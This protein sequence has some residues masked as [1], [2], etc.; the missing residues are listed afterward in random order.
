MAIKIQH[1]FF[2]KKKHVDVKPTEKSDLS[3]SSLS[4]NNKSTISKSDKENSQISAQKS[5]QEILDS[6]WSQNSAGD[7]IRLKILQKMNHAKQIKEQQKKQGPFVNRTRTPSRTADVALKARQKNLSKLI[8]IVQEAEKQK[9][10]IT[11]KNSENI[12]EKLNK[13]LTRKINKIRGNMKSVSPR[14]KLFLN[15]SNLIDFKDIDKSP[16]NE[17]KVNTTYISNRPSIDINSSPP[18]ANNTEK[19][20]TSMQQYIETEFNFNSPQNIQQMPNEAK[21]YSNLKDQLRQIT[22]ELEKEKIGNEK[23]SCENEK[24]KKQRRTRDV[25]K[26]KNF[27]SDSLASLDDKSFEKCENFDLADFN[28]TQQIQKTEIIIEENEEE[29]NENIEKIQ[30]EN[31]EILENNILKPVKLNNA[32][33]L[34]KTKIPVVRKLSRK[35]TTPVILPSKN[36]KNEQENLLKK[37]I[38]AKNHMAR[39]YLGELYSKI[40]FRIKGTV[41][42]KKAEKIIH[43]NKQ[44]RIL[45]RS[46]TCKNIENKEKLKN[47]DVK[48]SK[49]KIINKQKIIA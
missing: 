26:K 36:M 9:T 39:R 40:M 12:Q 49:K 20:H 27:K 46:A 14:E 17:S 11:R 6:I 7:K 25:R 34:E 33:N 41:Q 24:S 37:E 32:K 5:E 15:K 47:E 31:A 3:S 45:E 23:N 13:T 18:K 48:I 21:T 35:M 8:V 28:T 22:A 4:V 29:N 2:I 1:W 19:S 43:E 30:K 42:E 44:K 16:L 10:N 38:Q